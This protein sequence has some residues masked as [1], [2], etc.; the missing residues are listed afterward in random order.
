[1][2]EVSLQSSDISNL[3]YCFSAMLDITD[4]P[5]WCAYEANCAPLQPG[6]PLDATLE[7][8]MLACSPATRSHAIRAPFLLVIGGK[9]LRVSP[10]FRSFVRG[11]SANGVTHKVLYYPESNHALDEVDVETDVEINTALWFQK[12]AL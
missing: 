6:K 11:L 3:C 1:M 5:D 7:K 8:Q 4:I 9:D 12:Y 2:F 10:H